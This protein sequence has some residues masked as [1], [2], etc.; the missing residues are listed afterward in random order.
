MQQVGW[1]GLFWIGGLVS[2]LGD[3]VLNVALPYYVYQ[4]TGSA[5]ATGALA[6]AQALPQVLIGSVAGVFVDRW[7]RKRTMVAADLL[8]AGLL[9]LLPL[10]ASN[11]WFW[12][13]KRI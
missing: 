13:L 3:S 12:L 9:L 10:T 8:R 5:A 11:D 4:R 1:R 7:D 6:I 2:L